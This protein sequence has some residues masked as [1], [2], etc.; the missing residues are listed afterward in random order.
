MAETPT[1]AAHGPSQAVTSST[2]RRRGFGYAILTPFS[3]KVSR[4]IPRAAQHAASTTL[5][6]SATRSLAQR[7]A[8]GAHHVRFRPFR[9]FQLCTR[10]GRRIVFFVEIARFELHYCNFATREE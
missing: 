4:H 3:A 8:T 2:F 10:P 1:N 5:A 7:P 6:P 9:V